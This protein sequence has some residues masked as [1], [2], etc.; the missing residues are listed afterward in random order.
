MMENKRDLLAVV[1]LRDKSLCSWY[2]FFAHIQAGGFTPVFMLGTLC[3]DTSRSIM[4]SH[5]YQII[6]TQLYSM[7]DIQTVSYCR[8]YLSGTVQ[9]LYTTVVINHL[10]DF[11]YLKSIDFK[12]Q[13]DNL[14][15]P[16]YIR[17]K[18]TKF[19]V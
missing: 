7:S 4:S 14:H 6:P 9:T 5:R 19:Y 18:C 15:Q 1:W 10:H 2:L 17:Y 13:Q 8:G 11:Y 12:P 16:L 3:P